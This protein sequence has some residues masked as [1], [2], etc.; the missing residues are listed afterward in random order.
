M[1]E[2]DRCFRALQNLEAENP[3][4][5][6]SDSPTQRVSGT[7]ADAFMPVTHRQPM[8]SLV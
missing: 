1:L 3:Q 8:L 5:V 6:T 7:P 2:Y 4:L